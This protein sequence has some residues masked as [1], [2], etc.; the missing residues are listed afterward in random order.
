M[1]I[2]RN[3]SLNFDNVDNQNVQEKESAKT[4]CNLL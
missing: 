4:Y 3:S 2:V 1:F